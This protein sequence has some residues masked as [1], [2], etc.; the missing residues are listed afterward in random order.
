MYVPIRYISFTAAL[1]LVLIVMPVQVMDHEGC[2]SV[3]FERAF[4]NNG[5][6]GDGKNGGGNAGNNGAQ[7]RSGG[8]ENDGKSDA[9][10]ESNAAGNEKSTGKKDNSLNV[11]H[12]NGMT[13]SVQGGRYTMKD[14]RG[15]TIIIRNA[16]PADQS[17][18]LDLLR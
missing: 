3:D 8:N 14:A 15:R 17:R 4:A 13:E 7:G 11:Q 9:K 2:L 10:G 16:K 18:L 1:T 12:A 5:N 6:K